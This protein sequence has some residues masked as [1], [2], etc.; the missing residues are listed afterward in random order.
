M[1]GAQDA[2]GVDSFASSD[3][4]FAA[5]ALFEAYRSGDAAE[6]QNC[7]KEHN[8]FLELDNQVRA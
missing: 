8:A 5:E 3:G 7:V 4:A 2:M 1:S 6:I